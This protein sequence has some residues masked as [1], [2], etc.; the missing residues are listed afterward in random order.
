MQYEQIPEALFELHKELAFHPDIQEAASVQPD[1]PIT[2]MLARVA[3]CLGY[4]AEGI[5]TVEYVCDELRH[6]LIARRL[7]LKVTTHLPPAP[8]RHQ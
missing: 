1:S 2:Q 5:Y 8:E 3:I 4:S 7:N 6:I